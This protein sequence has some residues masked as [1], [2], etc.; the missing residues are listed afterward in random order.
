[1]HLINLLVSIFVIDVVILAHE[2]GH[3]FFAKRSGVAV[4]EF[5][6]GLGPK[7]YSFRRGETLFC[8]RLF[9]ILGYVNLYGDEEILAGG[10][11]EKKTLDLLKQ[12]EY[13]FE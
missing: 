11:E 5:S 9:P 10:E 1:M 3:Y 4:L 13:I 8:L 6:I 12:K 7:L 2:I